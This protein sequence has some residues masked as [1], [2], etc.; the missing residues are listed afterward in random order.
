MSN[1]TKISI[2]GLGYVGLPLAIEFSL[3]YKVIGYDIDKK[4]IIELKE[5]IDK[6]QEIKKKNQL[7]NKNIK[8]TNHFQDMILISWL[9][10]SSKFCA[11]VSRADLVTTR[12]A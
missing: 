2:I 11:Q 9:V 12:G 10:Y 1:K 8:F 4:R 6:T 7:N 5:G 3:K